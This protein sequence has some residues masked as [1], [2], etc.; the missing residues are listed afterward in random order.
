MNEEEKR[1]SREVERVLREILK[2]MYLY[3]M[4]AIS[5]PSIKKY[6][7]GEKNFWLRQ[8][9]AAQKKLTE[10][11]NDFGRKI[12]GLFVNSLDKAWQMGEDAYTSKTEQAAKDKYEALKAHATQQQRNQ[13]AA[14]SARRFDNYNKDGRTFSSRIWKVG[15]GAQSE[16]EVIIQ[17]AIKEGKSAE[18]LQKELRRYLVEPNRVYKR[19]R[20]KKTGKLEWSEAAKKYRP[21]QGVYRSSYKNAMRLA[22]T[23]IAASYRRA[24]WEKYQND[25]LVI[26][27]RIELSNNHTCINPRTGE[28]EP[29]HDI[30][31]ELEGIYP[32]TFLWTGWHPQCRCIMTPVLVDGPE[33][34]KILDAEEKG[35][36]YTPKGVEKMPKAFED[37]L[38][39]NRN[40]VDTFWERGTMPY[41]LRDNL[42]LLQK[43]GIIGAQSLKVQLKGALS[44]PFGV[45][46]FLSL[47]NFMREKVAPQLRK[48]A[49]ERAM[50][51]EK[52]KR[53]GDVFFMEGSKYSQIEA[54]TAEKLTKAGYSV[55]F[56]GEAHIKKIKTLE[57]DKTRRVNDVYLY[58]KKTYIQL[59]AD[60]KTLGNV[61][62]ETV[63]QHIKSGSGQA[64]VVVLDITGKI[65]KTDLITGLRKGW[66]D[67][68]K[69]V[70]LNYKGQ[71]YH[72]DEAR[73]YDKYY[74]NKTVQ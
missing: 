57:G 2:L 33:F 19:V 28:P 36:K 73:V 63:A 58:D 52:H 74:L 41:W 67:D 22:R 69:T 23:E 56:P 54:K 30:C 72:L 7:G 20:D 34:R 68:V 18:D 39:I 43:N 65:S 61:S 50:L 9:P 17:N 15:D 16:I 40:R 21:G 59:K 66:N 51:A 1:L 14:S 13:G 44:D 4:S 70:L 55:V 47:Y 38:K 42:H 8:N 49:F 10:L 24:Q 71:W 46:S 27:I 5:I 64:P 31:D 26:G 45:N 3:Y 62:V 6:L 35:E 11:T 12:E 48:I 29:F 37:W 53:E 25:P 60:L 32:K